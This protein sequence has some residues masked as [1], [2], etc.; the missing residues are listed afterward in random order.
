MTLPLS[1]ID[2]DA[3]EEGLGFDGSSIRGW[4]GISGV[5]MLLVPDPATAILDPFT[6][7]TTMSLLCGVIDPITREPYGGTRACSPSSAE[8][9]LALERGRRH[10]VLR[11]R[12][13][14]SSSSTTSPTT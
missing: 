3:F 13:R 1:A 14:S 11:P 7:V 9:Y 6:E 4:K 2:E 10:R 5:D 8:A 12:E